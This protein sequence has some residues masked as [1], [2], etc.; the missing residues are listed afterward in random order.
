MSRPYLPDGVSR[1]RTRL[2]A[3]WWRTAHRIRGIADEDRQLVRAGLVDFAEGARLTKSGGGLDIIAR[4]VL[5]LVESTYE[6]DDRGALTRRLP[7]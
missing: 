6:G 4:I 1:D 2:R 3:W 7:D 5:E